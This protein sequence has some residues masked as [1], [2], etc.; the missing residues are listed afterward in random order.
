M[1]SV[2]KYF[3]VFPNFPTESKSCSMRIFPL[4]APIAAPCDPIFPLITY[5][6][7]SPLWPYCFHIKLN[8]LT[9]GKLEKS[10]EVAIIFGYDF[11]LFFSVALEQSSDIS[12]DFLL[13]PIMWRNFDYPCKWT[14]VFCVVTLHNLHR[15]IGLTHSTPPSRAPTHTHGQR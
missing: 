2:K 11:W 7:R 6:P 14:W 8:F 13:N 10:L 9:V 4:S 12:H 3:A 5:R 15:P 1:I